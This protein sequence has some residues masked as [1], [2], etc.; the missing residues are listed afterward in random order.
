MHMNAYGCILMHTE[1]QPYVRDQPDSR[2][3]PVIPTLFSGRTPKPCLRLEVISQDLRN[4]MD[5]I[6]IPELCLWLKGISQSR[7]IIWTSES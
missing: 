1:A 5:L 7:K 2:A 6:G 4:N 3:Q